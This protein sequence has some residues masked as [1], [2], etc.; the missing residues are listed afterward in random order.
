MNKNGLSCQEECIRVGNWVGGTTRQA[1][2]ALLTLYGRER[3]EDGNGAVS[4][5]D[6]EI[7]M[8]ESRANY[9]Q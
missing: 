1:Y 9:K 2:L 4:R 6:K 7:E 8:G 5:G 3:E